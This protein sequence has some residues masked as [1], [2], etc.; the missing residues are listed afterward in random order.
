MRDFEAVANAA[1][2]T[3][4]RFLADL[5][6]HEIAQHKEMQRIK[7]QPI[8]A[9]PVDTTTE[10]GGLGIAAA[11]QRSRQVRE[12]N[13]EPPAPTAPVV[14]QVGNTNTSTG[15][16]TGPI[17][18]LD[19]LALYVIKGD[20]FLRDQRKRTAVEVLRASSSTDEEF[21]VLVA[22]LE[23]VIAVKTKAVEDNNVVGK[24]AHFAFDKLTSLLRGE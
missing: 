1:G 17:S 15:A 14:V 13:A 10:A 19:R 3:R 2:K 5:V 20:E 16:G 22:Q 6:L 21:N 4:Q 12:Q 11:L 23:Q 24:I 9:S 7:K 18:E 8:G